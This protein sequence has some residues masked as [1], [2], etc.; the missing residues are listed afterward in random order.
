MVKNRKRSHGEFEEEY[1]LDN[2]AS[3]SIGVGAILANLKAPELAP[4]NGH[5]DARASLN[6]KN[7]AR[8]PE[9]GGWIQV[10]KGSRHRQNKKQKE[11]AAE[12]EVEAE[13]G[14]NDPDK[15]P[16]LTYS[17]I[18]KL[19]T[20]TKLGEMQDL[21][22]YC[23]ADTT[24]PKWVAVRHHA[25]IQKAVVLLV[26]G[27]EKGMFDRTIP[28][29]DPNTAEQEVNEAEA[30]LNESRSRTDVATQTSERINARGWANATADDY[31]PFVLDYNNLAASLQPLSDIF[32]HLWPIKTPGDDKYS[33]LYSP[34]HSMLTSP[35]TKSR[36]D[37]NAIK[38]NWGAKLPTSSRDWENEPTPIN[39]FL[40]S[41][42]DLQGNDYTLHPATF[43]NEEEKLLEAKR[44][45]V[46]K[47][48]AED[49]WI[50]TTVNELNDGDM[51]GSSTNKGDLT[52]GRTVFAMDCEM[53]TVEGG[54]AALTRISLVGW[55]GAVIMDELVK[56][57]KP[58]TDYL[59]P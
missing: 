12:V 32:I 10:S 30:R 8:L 33:R 7:D 31:M 53:C 18:H 40:T 44:R 46:D 4:S 23:L 41:Q 2:P 42:E 28:L 13:D 35:I 56:P 20:M 54:E 5:I 17:E 34:L 36:E 58:I 26:P 49:G 21:V 55:D 43:E 51:S 57:D 1:A 39:E 25:A 45:E 3:G 14:S 11:L 29:T 6:G 59:T 37:R 15:Y 22:L 48:T 50:D 47:Q 38:K 16:I 19:A 9:D 27:L 52:A 24:A